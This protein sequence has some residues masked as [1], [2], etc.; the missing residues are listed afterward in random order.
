MGLQLIGFEQEDAAL[1]ELARN[2]LEEEERRL[3]GGVQ[4][5]EGEDERSRLRDA[6]EEGRD[7]VEQP[8]AGSLRFR[9]RRSF[10]VREEVV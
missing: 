4:I 2:V 5:V 10:D 3:V 6:L 7:A 1:G 8:E 9:R